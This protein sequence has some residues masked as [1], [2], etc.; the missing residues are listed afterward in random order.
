MMS[1]PIKLI[2]LTET[3]VFP[4]YSLA[5]AKLLKIKILIILD[6]KFILLNSLIYV[7]R[8]HISKYLFFLY[9]YMSLLY[10]YSL[11][12]FGLSI[13]MLVLFY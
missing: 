4:F 2:K 12:E 10:Q 9:A 5:N 6:V 11:H 3:Y 7:I 13:V 8:V 1:L